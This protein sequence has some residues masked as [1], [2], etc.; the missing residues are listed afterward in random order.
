ML[1]HP[2]NFK[3]ALQES[4]SDYQSAGSPGPSAHLYKKEKSFFSNGMARPSGACH[5]LVVHHRADTLNIMAAMFRKFG[6]QVTTALESAKALLYFGRKPCDLL[7]TD[8]DMPV[9]NGYRLACLIKKHRPE[10]KAVIMTCCC[11]A[12]LVDLMNA[13][14]VDGWLFKPFKTNEFKRTLAGIG[15]EAAHPAD[16]SGGRE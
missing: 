11:Q 5:V 2:H 15:L 6:Y 14:T 8:L 10:T 13:G 9:L 1:H 12:E 4:A 3:S 16:P 7:F